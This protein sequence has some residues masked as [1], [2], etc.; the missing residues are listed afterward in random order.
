MFPQLSFPQRENKTSLRCNNRVLRLPAI[1]SLNTTFAGRRRTL[2]L[3]VKPARMSENLLD[4][5][6]ES[7]T[8]FLPSGWK[9]ENHELKFSSRLPLRN[10]HHIPVRGPR[11]TEFQFFVHRVTTYARRSGSR[12]PRLSGFLSSAAAA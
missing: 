7:E 12:A 4:V 8:Y 11:A 3:N 6:G 1:V 2:L 5:L 10:I 9:L